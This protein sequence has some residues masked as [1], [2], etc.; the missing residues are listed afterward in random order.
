VASPSPKGCT[1]LK[2]RRLSRT[3]ARGYDA[4]MR[5]LE[6]TESQYTLLSHVV[7]LGPI[8]PGALAQA[9]GLDPSTLTRNLRALLDAGW[10]AQTSPEGRADRRTRPLVATPAGADLRARA[11]QRWRISQERINRVL[12][13]DR[14]V[15][16][17]TLLDEC[18]ALLDAST[19]ETPSQAGVDTA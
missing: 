6:L 7:R 5:P 9:L 17:H 13:P 19:H 12:G 1:N 18:A 8:A 2:L 15:A 3:V 10:I 14:V 11:Q 4:D 16:L